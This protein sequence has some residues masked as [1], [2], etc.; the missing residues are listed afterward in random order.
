MLSMEKKN[1]VEK[2]ISDGRVT[3]YA[4]PK[5][6]IIIL[7]YSTLVPMITIFYLLQND[8]SYFLSINSYF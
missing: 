2:I 8:M 7:S 5:R 4:H 3:E 1:M 6:F